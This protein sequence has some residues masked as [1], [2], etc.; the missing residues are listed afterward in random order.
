MKIKITFLS[1]ATVFILSLPAYSV[2][3][4]DECSD[5]SKWNVAKKL[6]CKIKLA[7]EPITA[8]VNK[9]TEGITSKKTIADFFKKKK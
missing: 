6:E 2:E 4:K 9:S 3:K 5:I 7:A 8:K 1:L